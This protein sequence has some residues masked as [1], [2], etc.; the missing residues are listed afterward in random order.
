MENVYDPLLT[1]LKSVRL[2]TEYELDYAKISIQQN[3]AEKK[4]TMMY[5]AIAFM[6]DTTLIAKR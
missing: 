5:N 3:L 6:D 1:K 2:N 4:K